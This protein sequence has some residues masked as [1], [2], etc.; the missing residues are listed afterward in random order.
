MIEW[1]ENTPKFVQD[2]V[3][4]ADDRRRQMAFEK[5][6]SS[7]LWRGY[8]MGIQDVINEI[9]SQAAL[10]KGLKEEGQ[11][12]TIERFQKTHGESAS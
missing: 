8:F 10:E 2:A 11:R 12:Q 1:P 4:A 7:D 9:E 6:I 5:D 3:N